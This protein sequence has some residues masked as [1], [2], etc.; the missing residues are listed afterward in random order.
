MLTEFAGGLSGGQEQPGAGGAA[1]DSDD[2]DNTPGYEVH[3]EV[4]EG[5]DGEWTIMRTLQFGQDRSAAHAY[6]D[7]L[8]ATREEHRDWKAIVLTLYD[9]VGDGNV[10]D[11]VHQDLRGAGPP[12]RFRAGPPRRTSAAAEQ[13]APAEPEPPSEAGNQEGMPHLFDN[14][15]HVH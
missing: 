13:A 6:F 10:I 4:W 14:F 8:V 11:E 3:V 7:Q 2:S 9:D 1:A 5:T 15:R 12:R